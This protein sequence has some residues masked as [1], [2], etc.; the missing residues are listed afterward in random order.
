MSPEKQKITNLLKEVEREKSSEKTYRLGLKEGIEA[1]WHAN[2][3]RKPRLIGSVD[4]KMA[5]QYFGM[6]TDRS[7]P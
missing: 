7:V 1:Q 5:F 3:N 4:R 2:G 6:R